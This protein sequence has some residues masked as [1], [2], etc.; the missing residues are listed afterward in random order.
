MS[1]GLSSNLKDKVRF[2]LLVV[3]FLANLTSL[4][5]G[6]YLRTEKRDQAFGFMLA[7]CIIIGYI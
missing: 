3:T 4:V 7:N 1:K 6:K 5:L 2:L